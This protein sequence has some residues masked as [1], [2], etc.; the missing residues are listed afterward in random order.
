MANDRI[1]PPAE[2]PY[3]DPNVKYTDGNPYGELKSKDPFSTRTVLNPLSEDFETAVNGEPII[4]QK[5]K[6]YS[7]PE[8][9]VI[10]V[11]KHIARK[12]GYTIHNAQY[13]PQEHAPSF[14]KEKEIEI[15]AVLLDK[16]ES[17]LPEVLDNL[18]KIVATISGEAQKNVQLLLKTRKQNVATVELKKENEAKALQEKRMKRGEISAEDVVQENQ[19]TAPTEQTE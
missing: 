13:L 2:I 3:N 15:M 4:V 19:D 14:P 16:V 5:G 18:N 11:A 7:G 1:V 10:H 8:F 9:R 12:I 6:S 17:D